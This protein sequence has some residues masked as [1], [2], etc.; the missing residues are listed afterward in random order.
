M[1]TGTSRS[2]DEPSRKTTYYAMYA[3][4]ARWTGD[5]SPDKVVTVTPRWSIAIIGGYATVHGVRLYHY[6]AKCSPSNSA[7][8]PAATFTLS[9][10][11][12]GDKVSFQGKYCHNGKCLH[13]NGTFR[14]NAKSRASIFIFYG[15]KRVIGWTLNFRLRFP[16]DADHLAVRSAG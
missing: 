5:T 7:G 3:G 14:L 11:H 4:D 8:C 9:P 16:G 10:N 6:S 12:A 13:D 1:G 15:D 2:G